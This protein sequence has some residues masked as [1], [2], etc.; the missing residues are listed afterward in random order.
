ME[1]LQRTNHFSETEV[2]LYIGDWLT[3]S[4]FHVFDEK[5]NKERPQWGVF[6]VRNINRGKR[7]DLVVRGNLRAAHT[8]KQDVYVAI[9]IKRGYKHHDILNGFDAIL[10]YF[11]DYLWGAEYRI[12]NKP[13]QIAA[14]VFATFFSKQGFLFKE[15]GKF[16]PHGIVRGP[17]D[18]YPMTFTISRLLWRQ[19]VNLVKR[20]QTLTGIP[21][22]EKKLKGRLS[23]GMQIPEI[24]I[25]VRKPSHKHDV[26]LML[27]ENPYHWRF[28]ASKQ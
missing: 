26:L 13:I 18:A 6:E 4:G 9:E 20:F 17:W 7:L 10:D 5:P 23:A 25:L 16:E 1:K 11:S 14:F 19:K 27:S 22:V 3:K 12:D 28:E 15:E 24:G 21:K 2:K 8:L